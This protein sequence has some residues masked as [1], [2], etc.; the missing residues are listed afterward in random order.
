MPKGAVPVSIGAPP[1]PVRCRAVHVPPRPQVRPSGCVCDGV[2]AGLTR[3][4]EGPGH[5]V[6]PWGPE[7]GACG[8]G[9][10]GVVGPL[11]RGSP[12]QRCPFGARPRC[13]ARPSGPTTH[14]CVCVCVCV[15][16]AVVP[17][18]P[19]PCAL[20][21]PPQ[22]REQDDQIYEMLTNVA[23]YKCKSD[24]NLKKAKSRVG[25]LKRRSVPPLPRPN[26]MPGPAHAPA[27]SDEDRPTSRPPSQRSS[28]P[29]PTH[30]KGEA[31]PLP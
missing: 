6:S 23:R 9:P 17:P 22:A 12:S 5:A 27:P 4:G 25:D 11:H 14:T 19:L 18:R 15:C 28:P 8:G 21:P 2:G 31:P 1:P 26:R 10:G 20:C 7:D 30:W 24:A 3:G 29:P 13:W 16:A